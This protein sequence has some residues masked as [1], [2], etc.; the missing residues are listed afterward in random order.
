M[1]G[2]TPPTEQRRVPVSPSPEFTLAKLV[3]H[4]PSGTAPSASGTKYQNRSFLNYILLGGLIGDF[5]V[6][7]MALLLSSWLRFE[8]EL[9]HVGINHEAV[10]WTD[11]MGLAVFGAL[12]FVVLLPHEEM[13]NLHRMR[14]L[15]LVVPG[16]INTALR[17]LFAYLTFTWIFRT[18]MEM[19]RIYAAVAFVVTTLALVG[20]RGIVVS[21]LRSRF[22]ASRIR[23]RVAFLGWS[24]QAAQLAR[25]IVTDKA[26]PYD[27]AGY[28]PIRHV[29][30]DGMVRP[31]LLS[32]PTDDPSRIALI[33][34][35]H[36]VDAVILADIDLPVERVRELAA[37][38]EKEMIDFKVIPDFFRILLSGLK[39]QTI[40]G[41]PILSIS[42]SPLNKPINI[43]LK[44]L[45]D[46]TGGLVGLLLSMPF[47]G[48]FGLWVYLEDP[49][50]VIFRQKRIGL[51]GRPFWILK[52][53]SMKLDAERDGKVGWTTQGD[54]RRL[55]IGAFMRRWNIDELPQFWNV[56]NGDMS[57]VGPRPERP[58]WI[59]LLKE[60]IPHY[61]VRHNIK[62][63]ITGWAQVNGL[64]GDTD[65]HERIRFDL[66]YM[67]HWSVLF[68]LKIMF[69][70]LAKRKNA[71]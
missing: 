68:D 69:A 13:Y 55:A 2:Q 44:Q 38:C 26:H 32:D 70:T 21:V 58:E 9:R 7:F 34:E 65:L 6:A 15:R 49:G 62:P 24:P 3:S 52:I 59:G 45:I 37:L 17:W 43:L 61:N 60:K 12:L 31:P 29:E 41:V 14:S 46:F 16:I 35:K 66:H 5:A 67:E 50:P 10:R 28:L 1:I 33:L 30:L 11:Y 27:V 20:W 53:R 63:G 57:L 71:C 4:L 40:S 36:K 54:P 19:S 56:L 18:S 48:A 64:R 25:C 39:L 51:D 22:F 23:Q 47:I 8:T 42:Y